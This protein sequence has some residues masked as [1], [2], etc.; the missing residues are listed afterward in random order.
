MLR[1]DDIFACQCAYLFIF[2]CV[3]TSIQGSKIAFCHPRT[4][5]QSSSININS[6]IHICAAAKSVGQVLPLSRN[7]ALLCENVRKCESSNFPHANRPSINKLLQNR[8]FDN[9]K[10]FIVGQ[11]QD[12]YFYIYQHHKYVVKDQL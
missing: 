6:F 9:I 5:R 1:E 11:L 3:S 10:T 4:N 12:S 7:E 8:H 2:W